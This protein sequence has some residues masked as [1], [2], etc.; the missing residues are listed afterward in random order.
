MWLFPQKDTTLRYKELTLAHNF[1]RQTKVIKMK[2]QRN[3]SQLKWWDIMPK[4]ELMK[5]KQTV[6]QIWN[7]CISKDIK[8]YFLNLKWFKVSSKKF[9]F[10]IHPVQLVNK[11]KNIV[12]HVSLSILLS[13][14]CMSSSGVGGSYG[15][16]ISRFSRNLNSVLHSGCISLLS[17]QQCSLF[18]TPSPA[19][20][21]YR[22]DS[23]H[24]DW[25]EMVP[26]CGFDLHFW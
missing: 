10:H 5:E 23:S 15:S 25:G 3:L 8:P 7:Q 2:R 14:G 11:W 6:H 12:L 17:N 1:R 20:I 22:L 13:L 26:H 19:F 16:S 9:Y 24:S 18:S 21:V 4:K